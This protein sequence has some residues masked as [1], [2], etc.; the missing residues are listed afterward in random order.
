MLIEIYIPTMVFGIVFM[1]LAFIR[2]ETII[3]GWLSALFFLSIAGASF[4]V[5]QF[6]SI[7]NSSW[8]TILYEHTFT[9][10]A[11]LFSGLGIMMLGYS[12]YVSIIGVAETIPKK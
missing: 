1:I 2:K 3:F 12:I 9:T 4:K 8:S 10:I 7:L 6:Y 11:I 5:E